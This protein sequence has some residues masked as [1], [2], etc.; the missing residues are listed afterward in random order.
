MISG[1]ICGVALALRSVMYIKVHSLAYR[2]ARLASARHKAF[3]P[4]LPDTKKKP[5]DSSGF[6][7]A[8]PGVEPGDFRSRIWRVANYTIGHQSLGRSS[9]TES[10][11]KDNKN[12]EKRNILTIF[13]HAASP[14]HA[15]IIITQWIKTFYKKHKLPRIFFSPFFTLI[16]YFLYKKTAWNPPISSSKDKISSIQSANRPAYFF[17]LLPLHALNLGFFYPFAS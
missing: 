4:A 10:G 9:L 17:F 16:K 8:L 6:P 15:K 1:G 3:C 11:C 5:L 13:F 14:I 2:F 12:T 7:V